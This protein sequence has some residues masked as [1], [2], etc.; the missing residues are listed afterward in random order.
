MNDDL[1]AVRHR[2]AAG[3]A[4]DGGRRRQRGVTLIEVMA[5]TAIS[6]IVLGMAAP[7]F[8]DSVRTNRTRSVSQQLSGLINEAR[9]EATK[10]NMPVLVCPSSNGTSCM[11]PPTASSWAGLTI[12]CYDANG[13]NA[14]DA[15]TTEAPNPIR[16]RAAVDPSVAVAGPTAIVRFNGMGATASATS[17][18]VSTGTK[19]DQSSSITLATTGAVRAY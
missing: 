2:R 8:V 7:S 10:R 11:S 15:S 14:C 12:V 17:F 4:S 19:S 1:L 3:K 5:T 13:D 9:V 16:V 6:A 18:S